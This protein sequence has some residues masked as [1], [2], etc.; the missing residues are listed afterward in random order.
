[1]VDQEHQDDV[2]AGSPAPV[3]ER[4]VPVA[5]QGQGQGQGQDEVVSGSQTEPGEPGLSAGEGRVRRFARR[6]QANEVGGRSHSHRV[7]VTAEEAAA[8]AQRAEE[9]GVS[10]PRLMVETALADPARS[11]TA[12]ERQEAMVELFAVRR[13]LAAVSN[14]VN[15]LARQANSTGQVP[16]EAAA[17]IAAARRLAGRIDGAID[18]LS[19]AGPRRTREARAA[20]AEDID[21][22][23]R[24]MSRTRLDAAAA[25][26]GDADLDGPPVEG[27]EHLVDVDFEGPAADVVVEHVDHA[28]HADHD[29]GAVEN[30]R[31]RTV[32]AERWQRWMVTGR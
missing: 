31:Q 8:L 25:A 23:E 18:E 4:P 14:N 5:G 15:Q 32:D 7:K 2:P 26:A 24:E 19:D 30:E 22:P 20:T 12:A 10:V 6:R 16:A 29:R 13:L 17:T 11:Q 28:D 3:D 27:D 21:V 1:V 9:R